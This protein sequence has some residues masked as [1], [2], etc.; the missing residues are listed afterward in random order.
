MYIPTGVYVFVHAILN[1]NQAAKFFSNDSRLTELFVTLISEEMC[2][3]LNWK[4]V[5]TD[6]M[7]YLDKPC[8]IF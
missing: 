1:K 6:E 3:K 2:L 4:V 8:L 5:Y 7:P